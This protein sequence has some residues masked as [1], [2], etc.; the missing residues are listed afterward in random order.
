MDLR[1]AISMTFGLGRETKPDAAT[2]AKMLDAAPAALAEAEREAQVAQRV[3][4]GLLTDK[5]IGAPASDTDIS[6]ARKS[7]DAANAKARS[8]R[9]MTDRAR[10]Q[11]TSTAA[12]EAEA[13]H[14]A[15]VDAMKAADKAHRL[16]L[17]EFAQA[18]A[19]LGACAVKVR[20]TLSAFT[21][22]VPASVLDVSGLPSYRGGLIHHLERD[23]FFYSRGAFPSAH[24][25]LPK[26]PAAFLADYQPM[27]RS[28]ERDA[29]AAI[30]RVEA[31][32]P[33]AVAN[34]AA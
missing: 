5:D 10:R 9:V 12:A 29:S 19:R 34:L 33:G 1:T 13:S 27:G 32:A 24:A 14:R 17:D 28:Y 31:A 7:L 30:E 22:L 16:A 3:L 20:G 25:V 8:L 11:H 4:D 23:T 21:G 2:L 15:H 6:R 26:M 18:A